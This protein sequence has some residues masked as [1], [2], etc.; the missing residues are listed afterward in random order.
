MIGRFLDAMQDALDALSDALSGFVD[1]VAQLVTDWMEWTERA[2]NAIMDATQNY[3]VPQ[4][5]HIDLSCGGHVDID[6]YIRN[7]G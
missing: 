2:L 4:S 7:P 1:A 5:A 3:G 6:Y